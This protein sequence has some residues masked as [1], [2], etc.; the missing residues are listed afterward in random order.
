M[1]FILCGTPRYKEYCGV[2]TPL[3]TKVPKEY[4]CSRTLE[5]PFN[6]QFLKE[7]ET[8][9]DPPPLKRTFVEWMLKVLHETERCLILK[10]MAY[11]K[12]ILLPWYRLIPFAFSAYTV[13][14]KYVVYYIGIK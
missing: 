11:V 7:P 2:A 10:V 1:V 6:E 3:K 13:Y 12:N 9:K 5:E 4:I 8:F 14:I